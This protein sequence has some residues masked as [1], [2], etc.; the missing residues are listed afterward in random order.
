MAAPSYSYQP[1]VH[2]PSYSAVEEIAYEDQ[3]H[4]VASEPQ[5]RYE[6]A[7]LPE[8]LAEVPTAT[9]SAPVSAGQL[10]QESIDAIARRV[11][12]MM[13]DKVVQDI[14]WE[15]VPDLAELLIK[16]RLEEQESTK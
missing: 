12:E 11:V 6:T 8:P 15:V 1:E 5:S 2:T 10:S 4:E 7:P 9:T 13:S 16:K 3:V 14:A